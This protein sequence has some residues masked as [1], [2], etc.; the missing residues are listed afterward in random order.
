MTKKET[1]E[2]KV[3]LVKKNLLIGGVA[4]IVIALV[5]GIVSYGIF[6]IK[7]GS[8]N[9]VS[10]T[11][12][13]VLNTDVMSINGVDI[14]Y[15]R[16]AKNKKLLT[17]V[18]AIEPAGTATTPEAINSETYARIQSEFILDA[19]A[20]EMGVSISIEE[21]E[22][23]KEFVW[24]IIEN[25]R[26]DIAEKIAELGW[27]KDEYFERTIDLVYYDVL[28]KKIE[29]TFVSST[30]PAYD[31]FMLEEVNHSQ[32]LVFSSPEDDPVEKESEAQA[33]LNRVQAGEEFDIVALEIAQ[34]PSSTELYNVSLDEWIP[35]GVGYPLEEPLFAAEANTLLPELYQSP[36]GFHIISI[37]DKR[38]QR[39]VSLFFQL[40][41]QEAVIQKYLPIPET[42]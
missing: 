34:V 5:V 11:L 28:A 31:E 42:A 2:K 27:D 10:T 9:P 33:I 7:K 1:G 15:S 35:K 40:R 6:G 3:E 37:G 19:L 17:A 13:K 24:N 41:W 26:A 29:K 38:S 18:R 21:V 12:A 20:Q 25:E 4:I 36:Y 16:F 22:D 30:E 39:D 23:G 8:V 14:P 32:I